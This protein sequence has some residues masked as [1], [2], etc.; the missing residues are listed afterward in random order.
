[1]FSCNAVLHFQLN[2]GIS[3]N[4]E[5]FYRQQGYDFKLSNGRIVLVRRTPRSARHRRQEQVG[6][7]SN[8]LTNQLLAAGLIAKRVVSTAQRS[9]IPLEPGHALQIIPRQRTAG[10]PLTWTG[11]GLVRVQDG[12]GLRFIVD[13]L[14]S[15]MDYQLV[16]RYEPEVG[17]GRCQTGLCC[18]PRWR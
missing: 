8:R 2:P 12:A 18:R 10:R 3:P 15:S 6:H 9:S 5:Q 13:N 16:I 11:Q 14:P 7:P 1:M 17:S 4:C